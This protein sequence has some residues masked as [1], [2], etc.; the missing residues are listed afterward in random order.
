MQTIDSSCFFLFEK[1]VRAAANIPATSLVL[2]KN[3][4]ISANLDTGGSMDNTENVLHTNYITNRWNCFF[5][6]LLVTNLQSNLSFNSLKPSTM[7]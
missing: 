2:H 6:L 7:S 4:L 3:S 1:K 5:F